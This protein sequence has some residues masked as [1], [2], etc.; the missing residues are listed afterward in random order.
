M[1]YA[2]RTGRKGELSYKHAVKS[3]GRVV[4]RHSLVHLEGWSN[5]ETRSWEIAASERSADPTNSYE[6]HV[7]LEERVSG[8]TSM[9]FRVFEIVMLVLAS[10]TIQRMCGGAC[11]YRKE[12]QEKETR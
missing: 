5:Q 6:V 10:K 1:Q 7:R 11:P 8:L 4:H 3:H 9:R 12:E 2:S